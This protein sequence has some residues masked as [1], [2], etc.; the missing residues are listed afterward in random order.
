MTHGG[1]GDPDQFSSD[2][3]WQTLEGICSGV[4]S[5]RAVASAADSVAAGGGGGCCDEEQWAVEMLLRG[6]PARTSPRRGRPGSAG[7]GAAAAVCVLRYARLEKRTW[8]VLAPE[9][10]VVGCCGRLEV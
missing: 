9:S 7:P 6:T 3:G 8:T 5:G 4:V 1:R 2:S 10:P